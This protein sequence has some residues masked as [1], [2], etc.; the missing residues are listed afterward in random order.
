MVFMATCFLYSGERAE[1]LS[2]RSLRYLPVVVPAAGE[3]RLYSPG[4]ILPK[5]AG[6][7][8]Y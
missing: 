6:T 5:R 4:E 8:D 7:S 1:T 3:F 2:N